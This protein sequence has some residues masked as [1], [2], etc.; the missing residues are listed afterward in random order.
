MPLTRFVKVGRI[1]NLSDARFC[2]GMGVDMLGF[3]VLEGQVHYL[4]SKAFQEIRGWISG[5]G[6]VAEV[7]GLRNAATLDAVLENYRPDYL[8][9]GWE[10]LPFVAHTDLPLILALQ[11]GE[12]G[13]LPG[14]A[15]AKRVTHVLIPGFDGSTSIQSTLPVMAEVDPAEA[16][17]VLDNFPSYG[18][19]LNGSPEIRPGLKSFDDLADVLERLEE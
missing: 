5:P 11:P 3:R 16:G 14:H 18:L 8:E 15:L 12:V 7:Y 1:S 17:R 4:S 10:E 9:L 13:R 6:I 19:A 2:A